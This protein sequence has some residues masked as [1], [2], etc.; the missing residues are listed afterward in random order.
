VRAEFTVQGGL[1]IAA[2]GLTAAVAV[3]FLT[4]GCPLERKTENPALR[5]TERLRAAGRARADES[6]ERALA[7]VATANAAILRSI[8]PGVDDLAR[9]ASET[10]GRIA[11]AGRKEGYLSPSEAEE[12]RLLACAYM[13]QTR[14]L[15]RVADDHEDFAAID[16]LP[17]RARTMGVAAR[18]LAGLLQQDLSRAFVAAFDDQK[19]A[20]EQLDRPLE[21]DHVP[22]R[23]FRRIREASRSLR[24]RVALR[25]AIERFQAAEVQRLVLEEPE[26]GDLRWLG[27]RIYAAPSYEELRRDEEVSRIVAR[28]P[29]KVEVAVSEAAE[30]AERALYPAQI[31]VSTLIGDAVTSTRGPRIGTDL[32]ERTRRGIVRPGDV[33]L[34]RCDFY[35]S[36]AFLPGWWGHAALFVGDRADLERLAVAG[37]AAVQP[38]L[39]SLESGHDLIEAVS[40]G[41]VLSSLAHLMKADHIAVLRPRYRDEE[42]RRRAICRAFTHLGKPYDFKFD[43][44]SDDVLVCSELCWRSLEGVIDAPLVKRFGRFT[45]TPDDLAGLALGERPQFELVHFVKDGREARRNDYEAILK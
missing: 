36:N 4:H 43:F 31:F 18:L 35:L 5:V 30:E 33:L 34:E 9:R 21:R 1:A 10:A 16:D 26:G 44:E 29:Q 14:V 22:P 19:L 42:A 20:R 39:A 17:A 8:A 7:R 28:G 2:A 6:P 32:I 13:Q 24:A 11:A 3:S 41:V 12:L 23:L 15:T 25:E 45:L 38:H 27:K 40:D 37:D